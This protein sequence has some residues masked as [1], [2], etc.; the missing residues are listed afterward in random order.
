MVV[1]ALGL[2]LQLVE[3]LQLTLAVGVLAP[4]KETLLLLVLVA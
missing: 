3:L 1:V 4:I 2:H